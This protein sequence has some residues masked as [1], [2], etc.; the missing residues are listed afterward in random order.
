MRKRSS[1]NNEKRITW[2]YPKREKA[3]PNRRSRGTF[4]DSQSYIFVTRHEERQCKLLNFVAE[5]FQP[6]EEYGVCLQLDL[7]LLQSRAGTG[8][9]FQGQGQPWNDSTRTSRV[10]AKAFWIELVVSV[11]WKIALAV[12]CECVAIPWPHN[13]IFRARLLPISVFSTSNR[14]IGNFILVWMRSRHAS[15]CLPQHCAELLTRCLGYVSSLAFANKNFKT[16]I[17]WDY[18]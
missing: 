13:L 8:L 3:L 5:L 18:T 16:S 15:P 11:D 10:Y 14:N 7:E 17:K 6:F 2:K 9:Y 12:C 1:K 4:S